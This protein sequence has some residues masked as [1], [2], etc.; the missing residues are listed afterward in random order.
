MGWGN[1]DWGDKVRVE[2]VA[3]RP[4]WVCLI[5]CKMKVSTHYPHFRLFTC[6]NGWRNI[7]KLFMHLCICTSCIICV[8]IFSFC[9]WEA[10]TVFCLEQKQEIRLS[11]Y[12]DT[13]PG[14]LSSLRQILTP[15]RGPHSRVTYALLSPSPAALLWC[16]LIKKH[17]WA[18]C[19]LWQSNAI[20]QELQWKRGYNISIFCLGATK[21][22]CVK[23]L[24]YS[25]TSKIDW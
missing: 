24:V 5:A 14:R 23:G 12:K 10:L 20:T 8:F 4:P 15:T 17:E 2:I 19:H 18:S 9:W 21:V 22:L 1:W 7:S 16:S 3:L 6:T 13:N 11:H 25:F